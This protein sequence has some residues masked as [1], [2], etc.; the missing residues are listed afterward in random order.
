MSPQT[1]PDKRKLYGTL[2]QKQIERAAQATEQVN[3][4]PS[5]NME[6]PDSVLT[7]AISLGRSRLK[8]SI[9]QSFAQTRQD[10]RRDSPA[11]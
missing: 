11:L 10:R 7:V 1:S 6:N 9:S 4:V 8:W 5:H 3:L 2:A